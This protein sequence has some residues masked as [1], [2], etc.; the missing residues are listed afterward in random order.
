MTLEHKNTDFRLLFLIAAPKTAE[1]ATALFKEGH[2]P[3][4]YQFK[5]QGT[6]TGS[7]MDLLGLESTEKTVLMSMMPKVFANEMLKKLQQRLNLWAANSGIAFTVAIS[8]GSMRLIELLSRLQP[9]QYD[10][11]KEVQEMRSNEYAM[12]MA[13][14]DQGYSEEVMSAARKAGATGGTVFHSRRIGSEETMKFWGIAVQQEREI[15]MIL[16]TKESKTPIMK[17]IGAECGMQSK[18][19]GIVLSLPIDQVT[20]LD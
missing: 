3:M 10:V 20:S 12:V 19:H 16:T 9:E 14:V 15:L 8:G 1:K 2:I 11:E 7:I 6:A 17:A 13:I 18:A 5:A 4:L